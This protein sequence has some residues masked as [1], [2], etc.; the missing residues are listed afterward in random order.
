MEKGQRNLYTKL[1]QIARESKKR[2]LII[3]IL[4]TKLAVVVYVGGVP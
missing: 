2:L 1:N 3:L 4:T